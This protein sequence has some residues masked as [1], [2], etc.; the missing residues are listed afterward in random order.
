M[1]LLEARETESRV[2]GRQAIALEVL[3]EGEERH[4]LIGDIELLVR[5]DGAKVLGHRFILVLGVHEQAPEGF[6]PAMTWYR[7]PTLR[8]V[9]GW[10]SP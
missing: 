4:L 6:E 10:R 8:T 1:R 7:V 3:D 5:G 9:I 2:Q